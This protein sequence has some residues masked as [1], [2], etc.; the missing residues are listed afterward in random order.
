MGDRRR[1]R[2]DLR[3]AFPVRI[4]VTPSVAATV[5]ASRPAAMRVPVFAVTAV[6][7]AM[8]W[9]AGVLVGF[10]VGLRRA[11]LGLPCVVGL[12]ALAVGRES[13]ERVDQ[14][15]RLWILRAVGE[16]MLD[17]VVETV[18]LLLGALDFT[19]VVTLFG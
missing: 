4:S 6:A 5:G 15:R 19:L 9:R 7:L 2:T 17:G 1:S 11:T 3:V 16:H 18:R 8:T 10:G 14:S 13:L 12:V